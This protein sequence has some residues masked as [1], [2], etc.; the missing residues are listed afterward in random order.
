MPYLLLRLQASDS[1]KRRLPEITLDYKRKRITTRRPSI[2]VAAGPV[3]QL[4]DL[5]MEID[6]LIEAHDKQGNV[7]GQALG[8]DGFDEMTGV[9]RLRPNTAAK[10]TLAMNRTFE[11]EFVV[12][13]LDPALPT[14]YATLPLETD[15]LL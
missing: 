12:K 6:L 5:D 1:E 14:T 8:G 2:E 7:V 10:V 15:Y 11:G 3:F 9:V 4:F 13:A